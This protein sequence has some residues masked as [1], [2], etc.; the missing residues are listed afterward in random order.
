MKLR[1]RLRLFRASGA[2]PNITLDEFADQM[3][4]AYDGQV[5]RSGTT[6]GPVDAMSISAYFCGVNLITGWMASCK[7]ILYERLD[8]R[9]KR[10]LKAD[11]LYTVI[12]DRFNSRMSAY[13]GWRT[14]VGHLINWGNAYALKL[15]DRY[16]G[17]VVGLEILHPY[18]VTPYR[19][20][21]SREL[22]YDVVDDFGNT[23][24]YT[25]EDVFHIPGPGFNGLTGFS[26]LTLARESLGLTAAMEQYGQQY[27]GQGIHAGGFLE[28]PP[29]APKLQ[30]EEAR[31][32]LTQGIAE[33]YAGL[34][35]QMKL[36][37]LEEGTK[38]NSNTLPLEDA[39][40]L[41][42][43]TFQIQEVARWLNLPPH[44][45]KELSRA[46][47]SN[48]EHQQIENMQDCLHPWAALIENEI[49][50]QL[51]IPEN[52]DVQFAEFL[53]ETLLRGDT[54]AQN[55]ALAVERQWGIISANEWR[56]IKNMN[57]QDGEQGEKYLVP[58]NYTVA[59]RLGET[60]FPATAPAPAPDDES[61]DDSVDDEE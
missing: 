55:N 31:K 47:F 44:K 46:T 28:R 32:R 23:R 59:E 29:E 8:E 24:T 58:S 16:R 43:R 19:M 61:G 21:G 17:A 26:V 10:R 6:M 5:T 22:I 53:L 18:T 7:C 15:R 42:S 34:G 56:A 54:V 20:K 48:I 37:L 30:S 9:S 25:R 36:I 39:Q 40:F 57:P 3:D 13:H 50:L 52:R 45:L 60:D 38:F 27:F 12:H 51:I 11:P 35:N 33:Q 2:W 1:E 49:G 41:G 4:K 14:L